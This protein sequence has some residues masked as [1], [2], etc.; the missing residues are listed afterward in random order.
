VLLVV[1]RVREF[2]ER[3]RRGSGVLRGR[4][5]RYLAER[6]GRARAQQAAHRVAPIEALFDQ[7]TGGPLVTVQVGK[8]DALAEVLSPTYSTLTN[9]ANSVAGHDTTLTTRQKLQIQGGFEARFMSIKFSWSFAGAVNFKGGL[10]AT[11]S[12][13]MP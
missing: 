5:Q 12:Q 9:L 8:S 11:N 1:E 4:R 7:V 13:A 2:L 3:E 10:L 6:R